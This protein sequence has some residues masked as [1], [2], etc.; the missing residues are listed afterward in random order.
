MNEM[1]LR[2]CP[3]I[4]KNDVEVN[5][6]QEYFMNIGMGKTATSGFEG[7][8]LD[9]FI[10]GRDIT[11]MNKKNQINIAKQKA[12][13]LFDAGYTKPIERN[14][15]KVLGKQALGMLYVGVDSL[16]AGD[17]ISDHDKKIANKIAYVLCGGDLSQ[18]T[19]V[20]EQYLLELE[21]DA[22]IS[23]CGERRTLERMQYML[24]NGKPL[25]N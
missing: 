24:K 3:K 18:P 14:D 25:R 15:I 12:L 10:K 2:A 1:L 11:V 16:R 17:Y 8:E 13:N 5:I 9:Y 19:K 6:L 4:K 23:L 22:F 21:R 7:Y 20:S